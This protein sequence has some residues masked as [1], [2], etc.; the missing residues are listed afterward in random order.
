[1][2]ARGAGSCISPAVCGRFRGLGRTGLR[3]GRRGGRRAVRSGTARRVV[4]AVRSRGQQQQ[5][6]GLVVGEF[7]QQQVSLVAWEDHCQR[8]GM[9][10]CASSTITSSG[11][12]RANSSRRLLFNEVGRDHQIRV[13]LVDGG[14]ER[15]SAGQPVGR[16]RQQHSASIPNLVGARTAIAGQAGAST[17]PPAAA[18]PRR[19]AA[20]PRSTQPR[21]SCRCQHRRRSAAGWYPG[22]PPSSAAPMVVAGRRIA[23]RKN[24]TGRRWPERRASARREVGGP[25]RHHRDR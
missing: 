11:Q 10:A 17:A 1:M 15:D 9:Q 23:A 7:A 8:R 13:V 25:G 22:R 3:A 4:A 20:P 18:R 2:S 24:G 16:G 5:V 6:A 14:S 19:P 21:R 12:S